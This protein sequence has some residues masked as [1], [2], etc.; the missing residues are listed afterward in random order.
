MTYGGCQA[1]GLLHSG[2]W[3]SGAQTA[4]RSGPSSHASWTQSRGSEAGALGLLL[5]QV[6]G[7]NDS[8][9]MARLWLQACP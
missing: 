2:L 6:P 5:A 3:V 4:G 9:G 8:G 7:Q 1:L